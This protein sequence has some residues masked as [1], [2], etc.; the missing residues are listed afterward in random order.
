MYKRKYSLPEIKRSLEASETIALNA[1]TKGHG[2]SLHHTI[3]D[4]RL[5]VRATNKQATV[6]AFAKGAKQSDQYHSV[7][8]LL[9]SELGQEALGVLEFLRTNTV[10]TKKGKEITRVAVTGD[11]QTGAFPHGAAR[12]AAPMGHVA[13]SSASKM[14][15]VLELKPRSFPAPLYIVTAFPQPASK[16]SKVEPTMNQVRQWNDRVERE[17]GQ[18]IARL[19]K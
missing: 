5:R 15:V 14:T 2:I 18:A 10:Q 16:A 6:S 9:N 12:F 19:F 13:T 3:S 7:A 1:F 4:V 8:F 17:V 11:I